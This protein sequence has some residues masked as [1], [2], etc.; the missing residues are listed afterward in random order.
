MLQINPFLDCTIYSGIIVH[1]GRNTH[2]VE[3][4]HFPIVAKV[5]YMCHKS[6]HNM[7]IR[8]LL[9]NFVGYISTIYSFFTDRQ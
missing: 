9:Y 4:N 5:V 7:N 3:S 1:F 8:E 6:S 2:Y